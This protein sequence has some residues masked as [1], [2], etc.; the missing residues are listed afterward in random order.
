MVKSSILL[1]FFVI[2]QEMFLGGMCFIF[3]SLLLHIYIIININVH[4]ISF[5]IVKVTTLIGHEWNGVRLP[6]VAALF[7]A[8]TVLAAFLDFPFPEVLLFH[9]HAI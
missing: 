2:N 5:K 7:S 9:N 3:S 4:L 8:A 6:I 1:L